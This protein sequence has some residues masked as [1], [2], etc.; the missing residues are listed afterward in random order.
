MAE[1]QQSIFNNFSLK[2]FACAL[3]SNLTIIILARSTLPLPRRVLEEL[4]INKHE[5]I[6]H[7]YNLLSHCILD[8]QLQVVLLN[9]DK[10]HFQ[11]KVVQWFCCFSYQ[12]FYLFL[13]IPIVNMKI[14]FILEAPPN[15]EDINTPS[16]HT[17]VFGGYV[18]WNKG[19]W[20]SLSIFF[21]VSWFSCLSKRSS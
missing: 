21:A 11:S 12:Y 7:L 8:A 6:M 3:T 16:K 9:W 17:L 20:R 13:V 5:H 18:D 15:V 1:P 14:Y 2:S 4:I 10:K 19:A